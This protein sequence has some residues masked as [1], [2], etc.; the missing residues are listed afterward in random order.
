V[1]SF[2]LR[3]RQFQAILMKAESAELTHF[4]Y[5]VVFLNSKNQI[6]TLQLVK[7]PLLLCRSMQGQPQTT[8]LLKHWFFG[9]PIGLRFSG[10]RL[11]K[12]SPILFLWTCSDLAE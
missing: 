9:L 8:Y 4:D 6:L 11:A 10:V 2:A 7:L 5:I 1:T 3:A 12:S